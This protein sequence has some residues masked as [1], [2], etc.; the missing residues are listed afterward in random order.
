MTTWKIESWIFQESLCFAVAAV[1]IDEG[2][3][4]IDGYSHTIIYSFQELSTKRI[5][6]Q[7]VLDEMA[8]C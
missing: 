4:T 1:L 2:L 7:F 8:V 6:E 3:P 5:R